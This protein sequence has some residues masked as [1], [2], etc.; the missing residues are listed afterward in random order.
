MCM[1][2][3]SYNFLQAVDGANPAEA[4]EQHSLE[5]ASASRLVLVNGIL[6]AQLSSLSSLPD[7]IYV[8][9]LTDAPEQAVSQNLVCNLSQQQC[10]LADPA[11]EA[12]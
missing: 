11:V 4:V 8:G 12:D 6:S 2:H 7:G 9:N 3:E 1:R 5:A 10:I